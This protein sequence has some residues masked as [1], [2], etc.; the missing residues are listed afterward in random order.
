[1]LL[2]NLKTAA[3]GHDIVVVWQ[4][5]PLNYTNNGWTPASEGAQTYAAHFDGSERPP[6]TVV[7]EPQRRSLL[8]VTLVGEKPL[9]I[10][11]TGSAASR[12]SLLSAS[13]QVE[14]TGEVS[15]PVGDFDVAATRG[16][17]V[18]AYARVDRVPE[19]GGVH[20]AFVCTAAV[21]PQKR[22]AVR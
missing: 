2:T 15:V 18:L 7:A 13:L 8:A 20:R 1:V 10:W 3:S 11:A 9:L 14:A 5:E 16:V 4:A 17:P 6:A 22:R 19:S 12:S 21:F